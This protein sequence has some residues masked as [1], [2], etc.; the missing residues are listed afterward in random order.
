MTLIIA[1]DSA[2]PGIR[3]PHQHQGNLRSSAKSCLPNCGVFFDEGKLMMKVCVSNR[4]A[5][6]AGA[7]YFH[8]FV[9]FFLS[10]SYVK[11]CIKYTDCKAPCS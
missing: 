4:F 9:F 10:I 1:P 2:N 11:C 3:Q 8:C 7:T 5:G 6:L